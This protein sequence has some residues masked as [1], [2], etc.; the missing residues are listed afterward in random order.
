M[1]LGK[2]WDRQVTDPCH[3]VITSDDDENCR[4][5]LSTHNETTCSQGKH[6]DRHQAGKTQDLL[7]ASQ[8]H[9]KLRHP[10]ASRIST[11]LMQINPQHK[12]LLLVP[13]MQG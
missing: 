4:G 13:K 6:A 12:S 1:S 9:S 7:T 5:N 3:T 2:W 11:N 8:K 10:A